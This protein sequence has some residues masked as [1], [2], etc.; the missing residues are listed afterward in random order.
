MAIFYGFSSFFKELL[1]LT[2]LSRGNYGK[3]SKKF[4][5]S[6]LLIKQMVNLS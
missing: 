4:I 3:D 5:F 6:L 2:P 1:A